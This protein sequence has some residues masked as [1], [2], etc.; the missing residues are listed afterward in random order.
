MDDSLVRK[1]MAILLMKQECK[2]AEEN[3]TG[4]DPWMRK[5]DI[6]LKAKKHKHL[7]ENPKEWNS[8]AFFNGSL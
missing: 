2:N 5:V 8:S 4:L 3:L 1:R 6:V 7:L